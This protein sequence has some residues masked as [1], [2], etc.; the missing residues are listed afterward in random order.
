MNWKR[1]RLVGAAS[2]VAA[3]LLG[4]LALAFTPLSRS[5][6]HWL[7]GSDWASMD[8]PA[9]TAAVGQ[10]RLSVVQVVAAVGASVALFYTA[11]TYRLSRRGQVTDRFTKALER[12]SSSESYVRMGGVFAMEQIVQD[13][14]DQASHAARVLNGFVRHHTEVS[15]EPGSLASVQLAD[16]P[17]EHV[18]EALRA[19]VVPRPWARGTTRPPVDLANLHLAKARLSGADLREAL[20]TGSTLTDADLSGADLREADLSDAD[21]TR[22]DLSDATGLEVQQVLSAR[23]LRGCRLPVSVAA[24]MDVARRVS[25]TV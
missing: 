23:S 7:S 18:Q 3:V 21:L 11:R 15:A 14:P 22:A 2:V 5:L 25:S 6:A 17:K 20:L 12:L 4:V 10:V 8:G 9:R 13:A 16:R 1:A 19:L 24:D